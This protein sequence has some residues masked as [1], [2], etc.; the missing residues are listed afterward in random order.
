[1]DKTLQ[2]SIRAIKNAGFS[3]IKLELEAQLD[4]D[5][6]ES[7][8]WECDGRG[9]VSCS[10]CD[11]EGA[12]EE[13]QYV[14][15]DWRTNWVECDECDGQGERSCSDCYGHGT[16]EGS[17]NYG[18]EGTCD[19]FIRD[20]VSKEAR[21]AL[22][23]GDFYN[24]GSVDSEYT[25]T[26]PIEKSQYLV[27]YINAFSALADEIGNGIDVDGSG[28]HI[29]VIPA[30]SEGR[31]PVRNFEMP[32]EKLDNFQ[33]EVTKLLPALFFLAS[34]SHRSRNLGY[35]MPRVSN[36]DKYSAIY[37]HGGTCF[38]YRLFETCYERPEAIF[39]YI[40]VVANT[41][42]FYANPAL[43][44]K[45]LGKR[46]GFSDGYE[47]SRFYDTPEQLRVLT[48]QIST[49]KPENKTIRQLMSERGVVG[50]LKELRQK[51]ASRVVR[52]RGD[53]L[54]MRKMQNEAKKR[55]L[56]PQQLRDIDYLMLDVGY[57]R[58]KAEAE[59]RGLRTL[60]TM[61]EFIQ[62]NLN[63]KSYDRYVSC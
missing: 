12:V 59:V 60:P 52:L 1:M 30:E 9:E 15:R 4:R 57:S 5:E 28:M 14:G 41:L 62:N 21:E 7:E 3:H 23:Y 36:E 61:R 20:Y 55:P 26:I 35:R 42:K 2:K 37:T 56:T 6:G 43:R 8:C 32:E 18:D 24:D 46:F 19:Q 39:D 40:A 10:Q 54:E 38:E 16:V 44:V 63:D 45:T 27:E 47:L 53:Y 25:F 50:T 11:G 29:S 48:S 13:Q 31:Y 49:I 22:V 33:N 58:D 51:Q 34:N 17:S